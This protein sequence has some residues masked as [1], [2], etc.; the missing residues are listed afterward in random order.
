MT[1]TITRITDHGSIVTVEVA[2]DPDQLKA[3]VGE[4]VHFDHSPFRWIVQ[5]ETS[6]DPAE[7]IGRTV[8]VHGDLG[9]QTLS[10]TD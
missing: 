4:S 1:G 2:T 9:S 6:G 10:F 7:L 5:A 8:E 3:G